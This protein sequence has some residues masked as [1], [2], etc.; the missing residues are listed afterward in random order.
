MNK[1]HPEAGTAHF[2]FFNVFQFEYLPKRGGN[3]KSLEGL[4]GSSNWEN[5]FSKLTNKYSISV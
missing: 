1:F 5:K 2:F 4:E 3:R